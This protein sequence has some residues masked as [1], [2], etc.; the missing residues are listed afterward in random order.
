VGVFERGTKFQNRLEEIM[1]YKTGK[2][3]YN[4]ISRSIIIIF[5]IL[6][7]PMAAG[8]TDL[9]SKE[10]VAD[11]SAVAI[12]DKGTVTT[13]PAI[14]TP[15]P[16]IIKTIPDSN[17]T[18]VDPDTNTLAV[19]FD[20]PMQKGMSW[21]GEGTPHFPATVKGV[22]PYW[23]DDTT[24]VLPVKL[25]KGK[26]YRLGLNSKSFRNFKS[27]DGMSLPPVVF[28]FVTKGAS[29]KIKS[30]VKVPEITEM[31][32]ENGAGDV[33]AKTNVLKVTFNMPMG[34]GM[35][36]T[37]GGPTF[38]GVVR[39]KRAKWSRDGKTCSLPVQLKPGINY[40]L[41]FNSLSHNNFQSKWGV[42]LK[43]VVYKF[44]TR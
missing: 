6:L 13:K 33:N 14:S 40:K 16:Q 2:R 9:S 24:C 5:G 11:D 39:G 32:P 36:W 17:A 30:R 37:G 18:D 23:K 43:P 29:D 38:P 22:K 8:I 41:G 15:Y 20:R 28:C 42:P 35:S 25:K 27:K 21:T 26:F 44:T 7:L 4:W 12:A 19:V 34:K 3:Q 10:T 1:N 31:N